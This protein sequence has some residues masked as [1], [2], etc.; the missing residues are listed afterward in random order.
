MFRSSSKHNVI[1]FARKVGIF[2]ARSKEQRVISDSYISHCR[3]NGYLRVLRGIIKVAR[4][5][6]VDPL[7]D[8]T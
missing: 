8:A 1:S 3:R 7:L 4:R 6:V 2:N 5:K